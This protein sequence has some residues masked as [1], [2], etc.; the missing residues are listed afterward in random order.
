MTEKP[1]LRIPHLR[2]K[3]F[4]GTEKQRHLLSQLKGLNRS[5]SCLTPR[6]LLSTSVFC[7]HHHVRLQWERMEGDTGQQAPQDPWSA[8][9]RDEIIFHLR[10]EEV[11][12][13]SHEVQ[14]L[15]IQPLPSKAKLNNRYTNHIPIHLWGMVL[16]VWG[17]NQENRVH[18]YT[19]PS[20]NHPENPAVHS[21]PFAPLSL[22]W[23]TGH[24]ICFF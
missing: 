13:A 2:G 15:E 1:E 19:S 21:L 9:G 3:E 4:R 14:V 22:L 6:C 12:A 7:T 16:G 23:T 8:T 17:A 10:N 18:K 20:P 5:P 11:M 24:T